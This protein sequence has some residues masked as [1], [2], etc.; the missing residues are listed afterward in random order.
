[1]ASAKFNINGKEHSSE[2]KKVNREDIYGD[3]IT[4]VLGEGDQPLQ[5][6]GVSENGKDYLSR[7]DLKYAVT[8]GDE[9]TLAPV[10]TVNP[11]TGEPAVQFPSSLSNPPEFTAATADQVAQIEV[12]AVYHLPDLKLDP[13]SKYIGS[14]NY[15]AG[16]EK[17]SAILI[18]KPEGSFLLV[19][20]EKPAT[21]VG[22]EIDSQLILAEETQTE[23]SG[24][25]DFGSLF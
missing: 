6:A 21:F 4:K 25:G 22:M 23:E 24:E 15:R 18:G 16:Y 10:R 8:A 17:K 3:T 14:F 20:Q 5:K 9:F 12:S 2:L 19:G 1:M 13:G 11:L 7:G